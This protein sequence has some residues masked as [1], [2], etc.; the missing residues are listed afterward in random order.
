MKGFGCDKI[1]EIAA[2]TYELWAAT[3][4]RHHPGDEWIKGFCGY[5]QS[6]GIRIMNKQLDKL[7]V[8]RRRES[9]RR[10]VRS[11]STSGILM[12]SIV[13][14]KRDLAIAML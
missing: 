9:T 6:L 7:A 8:T 4:P 5:F 14:F 12:L 13:E 11:S 3:H 10:H 2:M 1:A